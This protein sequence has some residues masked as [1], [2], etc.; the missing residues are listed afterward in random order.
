MTRLS[1]EGMCCVVQKKATLT[2]V[3]A[4]FLSPS[5]MLNGD[6]RSSLKPLMYERLMYVV[7]ETVIYGLDT[8]KARV[9][10]DLTE[11]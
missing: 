10:A 4:V 9:F 5:E 11:G 3:S 1:I 8:V 2:E 7:F 6:Y